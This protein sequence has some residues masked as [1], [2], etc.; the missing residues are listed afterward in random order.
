MKLVRF[1]LTLVLLFFIFD[2]VISPS[3]TNLCITFGLVV[4][5]SAIEKQINPSYSVGAIYRQEKAK[6]GM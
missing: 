3:L 6:R 1:L 2:T 5:L 4:A